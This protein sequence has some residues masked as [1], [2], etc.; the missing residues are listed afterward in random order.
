MV[1]N[2]KKFNESLSH[3]EVMDSQLSGDLALDF[4]VGGFRRLAHSI[5]NGSLSLAVLLLISPVFLLAAGCVLI[6]SGRPIFYTQW[7]VGHGGRLF[8]IIKFRTMVVGAHQMR[9]DI[10]HLNNMS[11]PFFK[12]KNDPRTTAVGRILRKLSLDELPQFLNVLKGEMAV[13]GP[14]P[15]L[16]EE[17]EE[18]RCYDI[19]RVKPGITGLWQVSGRSDVTDFNQKLWLDRLYISRRNWLLDFKIIV[20]TVLVVLRRSGAY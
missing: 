1:I 17:L 3:S 15:M 20:R 5:A 6:F 7:R 13:V 19:L 2:A 12:V 14:R 16:P 4:E 9:N 8:R 11:G 10:A 18:L